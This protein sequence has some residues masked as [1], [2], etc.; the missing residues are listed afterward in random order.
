MNHNDRLSRLESKRPTDYFTPEHRQAIIDAA[1][2]EPNMAE[3]EKA[4]VVEQ[5]R[6]EAEERRKK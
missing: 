6:L 1:F 5:I 2:D 3:A 4:A